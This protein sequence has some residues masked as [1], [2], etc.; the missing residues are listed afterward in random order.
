MKILQNWRQPLPSAAI[1]R[2]KFSTIFHYPKLN[3][4]LIYNSFRNKSLIKLNFNTI[5]LIKLNCFTILMDSYVT[6]LQITSAE[7]GRNS[8]LQLPP[9]PHVS[10][11]SL[12]GYCLLQMQVGGPQLLYWGG[13]CRPPAGRSAWLPPLH[14]VVG[15]SMQYNSN[16]NYI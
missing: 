2:N 11:F 4:I 13:A 12:Y 15:A 1:F 6:Y 10:P 14:R 5:A 9:S 8:L 16:F 7:S 3:S